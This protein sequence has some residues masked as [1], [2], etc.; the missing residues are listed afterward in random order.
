MEEVPGKLPPKWRAP[1]GRDN[2][3]SAD[4]WDMASPNIHEINIMHDKTLVH[5]SDTDKESERTENGRE[6]QSKIT[7]SHTNNKR[8]VCE[9]F[10]KALINIQRQPRTIRNSP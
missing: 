4:N 3:K 8:K 5:K 6:L 1:H 2:K 9:L 7:P 10:H